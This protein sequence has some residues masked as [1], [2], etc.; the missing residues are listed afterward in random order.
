LARANE[1]VA[2]Q[3]IIEADQN[4][5]ERLAVA[6]PQLVQKGGKSKIVYTVPALDPTNYSGRPIQIFSVN[7]MNVAGAV[8][9]RMGLQGRVTGSAKRSDGLEAGPTDSRE[10]ACR[11]RWI[12]ASSCRPIRIKRCGS[13]ST[14]LENFLQAFT[15][16]P[17]R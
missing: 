2:F 3:L 6:L 11:S 7:Y 14:P 9:R 17:S 5:I 10:R 15:P 13:R 8:A 1:I 4:G 16:G 12:S